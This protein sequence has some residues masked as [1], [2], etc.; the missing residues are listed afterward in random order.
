MP[1]L[2]H[3]ILW[4]SGLV[5][6]WCAISPVQIASGN[7][8]VFL[9]SVGNGGNQ[10]FFYRKSTNQGLTWGAPVYILT[11]VDTTRTAVWYDRWTTGDSGNL[12][13]IVALDSTNHNVT[14]WNLDTSSDTLTSPLVVVDGASFSTVVTNST[15]VTITKTRGGNVIIVYDGD[16]G[17]EDGA[18]KAA[19]P[20][21]S[22]S[23]IA[24]P[25]EGNDWFM[26]FP[27]N[28][29]DNQDADLLYWDVSFNE[30]SLKVYDDSVDSWSE[31]S[32]SGG[33]NTVIDAA[34]VF[35]QF[36]GAVR[37]SDGHLL[38]A[39]FTDYDTATA[40][41]KTWDINGTGSIT[42]KTDILTDKDDTGGVALLIDQSTDDVF[43]FH[44]GKG[45]GSEAIG[46]SVGI[47]YNKSSDDM[48]TWASEA[49]LFATIL[50]NYKR[51]G[52]NLSQS[53]QSYLPVA[54]YEDTNSLQKFWATAYIADAGAAGGHI[55][56][57]GM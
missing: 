56:G 10:D 12:I 36:T 52:C 57:G 26:A 16:G 40:D 51:I 29:A 45:D 43:V 30:L 24:D 35:P 19:S 8:Y 14:Y 44:L 55:I 46:S 42:A 39:A 7:W 48:V 41:L 21:T 37:H 31:A 47:Y 13:H 15:W 34:T 1:T 50:N 17:T 22:F 18:R 38:V 9:M 5:G 54:W 4:G 25:S 49:T 20:Y 3:Q 53:G 6:E 23:T 32:I 33:F 11:G 2:T 27:G 28:Y